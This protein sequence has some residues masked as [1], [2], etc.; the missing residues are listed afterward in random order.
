M[1]A[2]A[3]TMGQMDTFIREAWDMELDS[4]FRRVFTARDIF[5]HDARRHVRQILAVDLMAMSFNLRLLPSPLQTFALS[6][7]L[8][9]PMDALEASTPL[10]TR[11]AP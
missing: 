8:S 4:R 1:K 5:A 7:L 3:R 10:S 6:F 2:L 11:Y 9:G